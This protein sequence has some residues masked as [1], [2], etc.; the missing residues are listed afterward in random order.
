MAWPSGSGSSARNCLCH[1]EPEETKN[2]L[3]LPPNRV[4]VRHFLLAIFALRLPRNCYSKEASV[5][6]LLHRRFSK[7]MVQVPTRSA[8]SQ[9][10]ERKEAEA[11]E[12]GEGQS[13]Y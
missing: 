5:R 4:E 7:T 6:R 12:A 11:K 2:C 8:D 10:P 1:A 3:P 13:M 9:V